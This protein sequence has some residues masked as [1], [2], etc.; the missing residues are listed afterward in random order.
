MIR[1]HFHFGRPSSL[2]PHVLP[3]SSTPAALGGVGGVAGAFLSHLVLLW[4]RDT[5]MI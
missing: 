2:P 1:A 4:L 3:V 5:G